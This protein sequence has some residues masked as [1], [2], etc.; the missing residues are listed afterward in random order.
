MSP[1]QT[2]NVKVQR[3]TLDG[4]D[5]DVELEAHHFGRPYAEC[6]VD[7]PENWEIMTYSLFQGI[8]NSPFRDTFGLTRANE[9]VQHP[10]RLSKEQNLV[11]WVYAD[12]ETLSLNGNAHSSYHLDSLGVRYFKEIFRTESL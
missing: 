10:D 3:I 9:F 2:A 12:H 4:R 6:E 8:R 5:F 7:C 1:Q 11:A